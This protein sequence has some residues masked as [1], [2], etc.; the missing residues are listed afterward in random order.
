MFLFE[1]PASSSEQSRHI[2]SMYQLP[3]VL[4]NQLP[5]VLMRAWKLGPDH[6]AL[7]LGSATS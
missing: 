7:S 5:G 4:M 3:G 2:L 6:P 1:S